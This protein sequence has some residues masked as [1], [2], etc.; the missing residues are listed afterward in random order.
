MAEQQEAAA[1]ASAS[2]R[3]SV[4]KHFFDLDTGEYSIEFSDGDKIEFNVDTDFP[5][6]TQRRL[7]FHGIRQKSGDSYAGA[8]GNVHVAKQ[9]VKEVIDGLRAG[10]WNTGRGEGEARPRLGELAE[11]L[12][13][14]KGLSAEDAKATVEK[15]AA[16]EGDEAA[17]KAGQK[18][19][20]EIRAHPKVKSALAD[21]RAER[22]RK[23]LEAAVGAS[24]ELVL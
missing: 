9:N 17:K 12:E 20:A 16:L 10:E 23:E 18:K 4:A 8:K 24:G 21:I 1:Q 5:E 7:K 11:A 2:G 19:L 15:I 3:V 14:V 6:E 22:A 13:R